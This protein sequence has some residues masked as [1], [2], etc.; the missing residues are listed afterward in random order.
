MFKKLLYILTP[1][2]KINLVIVLFFVIILGLLEIIAIGSVPL[3]VSSLLNLNSN[4][5][6]LQGTFL[7][8]YIDQAN[9]ADYTF[10]FVIIVVSIFIFKNIFYLFVIFL[11]N[12]YFVNFRVKLTS[13]LFK[14]YVNNEYAFHLVRN[15]NQIIRNILNETSN[16][17]LIIL[18]L[19]T[20]IREL[21]VF[22]FIFALFTTLDPTNAIL[23]VIFFSFF[24]LVY[25]KLINKKLF[26]LGEKNILIKKM[27]Y[28]RINESINSIK[29]IKVSN[30]ENFFIF[31]FSK[32]YKQNEKIGFIVQYLGRTIRVYFEIV[33]ILSIIIFVTYLKYINISD[34]NLVVFFSF[35]GVA[36]VR[37]LPLF[38]AVLGAV[39]NMRFQQPSLNL[40]YEEYKKANILKNKI[41]EKKEFTEDFTKLSF[42]DITFSYGNKT[43]LKNINFEI[44]KGDKIGIVGET[45]CGKSTLMDLILGLLEPQ[46]GQIKLN[47]IDYVDFNTHY[48]KNKL[49]GFVPQNIFLLDD[50]IANNIFFANLN[51]TNK[52]IDNIIKIS[53]LSNLIKKNTEGVETVV[54]NNGIK[55]SGG[56]RQ[57]IGIAR[58]I[59]FGPKI[60]C[61][62][63]ATSNLD[64]ETENF[65]LNNLLDQDKNITFVMIAHRLSTLEKC[66]KVLYL[67]DKKIIDIGTIDYLKSKYS[68]LK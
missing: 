29:Y 21:I 7:Y 22:I 59:V 4:F 34:A 2:Q 39:T 5:D 49:F 10:Y 33:A 41:A 12:L 40:I 20:T 14:Y 45:G 24:M 46:S 43:I 58:S 64:T 1:K 26:Q 57:R 54:G 37:M 63:E 67:K 65:I 15:P 53:A 19:L 23:A 3:I 13:D 66:N 6:F 48:Y 9:I 56:E 30:T 51:K 28:S 60:L 17:A 36:F 27:L 47:N 44:N 42:K 25:Y 61:L 35:V 16:V 62:D 8:D 52:D 32:Y 38:T 50:T 18:G 31:D 68:I 11:E 55:I